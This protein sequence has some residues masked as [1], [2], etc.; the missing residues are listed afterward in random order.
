VAVSAAAAA[1]ARAA[2]AR[3]VAAAASAGVWVKKGEVGGGG[4]LI[5][6]SERSLSFTPA[7][8]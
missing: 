1:L 6:L 7:G 8:C 4:V 2:V 5:P 3:A